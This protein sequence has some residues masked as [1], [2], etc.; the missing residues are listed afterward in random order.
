MKLLFL[1]LAV[2]CQTV[3]SQDQ[4]RR[5]SFRSVDM[6]TGDFSVS[7]SSENAGDVVRARLNVPDD[8]EFRIQVVKGTRDQTRERDKLG[9][10]HPVL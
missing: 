8:F 10:V 1:V 2:W 7:L 3:F 9:F 5:T 6:P 4:S